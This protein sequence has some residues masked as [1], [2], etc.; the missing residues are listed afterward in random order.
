MTEDVKWVMEY[1]LKWTMK[2]ARQY[3]GITQQ[4]LADELDVHLQ[5][6]SYW[7]AGKFCPSVVNAMRIARI[8]KFPVEELFGNLL[9]RVDERRELTGE[10]II[11]S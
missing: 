10:G 1:D 8:L 11:K 2:K 5:Q 7:E 6:V 4:E 9:P 3:R